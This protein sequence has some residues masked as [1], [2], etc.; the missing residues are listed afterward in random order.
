MPDEVTSDARRPALPRD[1][2]QAVARELLADMHPPLGPDTPTVVAGSASVDSSLP[3]IGPYEV[4]APLGR[5]GMGSVYRARDPRLDRVVALKVFDMG[6]VPPSEA[7]E[8][9]ERFRREANALAKLGNHRH[10]VQV[11]EL[12]HDG[13][14]WWFS[15]DLVE[16]MT[17]RRW[18]GAETRTPREV[19]SM[20]Q[21]VA[22]GLAHAHA[23]G[24]IHRDVK[25]EN[26]FVGPDG[27]PQLGDFGLVRDLDAS[28]GITE[29]G[30]VMGTVAY[31]APE[32]ALGA[33]DRIGAWTDVHAVG[34][35]LYEGLTGSHPF[36]GREKTEILAQVLASEPVPLRRRNPRAAPDLEAIVMRCLEKE[37]ERRYRDAGALAEDLRRWLDG[38]PVTATRLTP[39][40]WLRKKLHRHR[41]SLMVACVIAVLGGA[42]TWGV[43]VGPEA[44]ARWRARD[45]LASAM[46]EREALR[47]EDRDLVADLERFWHDH[48]GDADG[49]DALVAEASM[50]F[51]DARAAR[52]RAFDSTAVG[53]PRV[54]RAIEELLHTAPYE[55][56][57]AVTS[58]PPEAVGLLVAQAAE[59]RD[60]ALAAKGLTPRPMD[61]IR[62]YVGVWRGGHDPAAR[63]RALE[64]LGRLAADL[65]DFP[66][67]RKLLEPIRDSL[68]PEARRILAVSC[69]EAGDLGA[70]AEASDPDLLDL[71]KSCGGVQD[72]AFD[73]HDL[74]WAG[75]FPA[76]RSRT[77]T[78]LI[79]RGDSSLSRLRV[80][81]E[82]IQVMRTGRIPIP[83]PSR[84]VYYA[85]PWPQPDGAP[86]LLLGVPTAQ[87]GTAFFVIRGDNLDV[88]PGP[89]VPGSLHQISTGDIDGDGVTEA[90]ATVRAGWWGIHCLGRGIDGGAVLLGSRRTESVPSLVL[91]D[92]DGDHR[93][94]GILLLGEYQDFRLSLVR[95]ANPRSLESTVLA[96]LEGDG[97][98]LWVNGLVD[99]CPSGEGASVILRREPDPGVGERLH[100]SSL[101]TGCYQ[102]P[103]SR[104]GD[105]WTM[106]PAR[107]L[108]RFPQHYV[109]GVSV[110][111]GRNRCYACM[112]ESGTVTHPTVL[113]PGGD[114]GACVRLP[115][116]SDGGE[117]GM[118]IVEPLRLDALG[119]GQAVWMAVDVSKGLFRVAWGGTPGPRAIDADSQPDPVWV[120]PEFLRSRAAWEDAVD[121]YRDDRLPW[122]DPVRRKLALADTLLAWAD[123]APDRAR[124]AEALELYREAASKAPE[125]GRASSLVAKEQGFHLEEDALRL[126]ALKWKTVR[127]DPSGVGDSLVAGRPTSARPEQAGWSLTTA[128][129]APGWI[130]V[131]IRIHSDVVR[132]QA[133]LQGTTLGSMNRLEVLIC[134]QSCPRESGWP[135]AQQVLERWGFGVSVAGSNCFAKTEAHLRGV[136]ATWDGQT[137]GGLLWP[138]E[139]NFDLMASAREGRFCELARWGK[140]IPGWERHGDA[141]C[142]LP[143]G[144]CWFLV[145]GPLW[146]AEE[147]IPSALG[148]PCHAGLSEIAISVPAEG[149]LE[150]RPVPDDPD[151]L[152][153]RGNARA[154]LEDWAGARSFYR[155]AL[156]SSSV[157]GRLRAQIQFWAAMAEFRQGMGSWISAAVDAFRGDGEASMLCWTRDVPASPEWKTFSERLARSVL[158]AGL[159]AH[160]GDALSAIQDRDGP[161]L[162]PVLAGAQGLR[163]GHGWEVIRVVRPAGGEGPE[164]GEWILQVDSADVPS[165]DRPVDLLREVGDRAEVDLR[166]RTPA[167][168]ER[169]IHVPRQALALVAVR[170]GFWIGR[171]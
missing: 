27:E 67:A 124:L 23:H 171:P 146:T 88:L 60:R 52:A 38:E 127:L 76:G 87:G 149:S 91:L 54:R 109:R 169:T 164:V 19:A 63:E 94:E 138:L 45:L 161:S 29:E 100:V 58:E 84:R 85:V 122:T 65:D 163:T 134:P 95:F 13:G 168:I 117:G 105:R 9:T 21:R 32:Q 140:S 24:V 119:S 137:L 37:P 133:H 72:L 143:D 79:L 31:M 170:A 103:V 61:A 93:A 55:A 99:S 114:R 155:R 18:L 47:S 167:G 160:G 81:T 10:L 83:A 28:Q 135:S 69:L 131:P 11:H 121:V 92:A 86:A 70:A 104:Q 1:L 25:P 77:E 159:L 157:S 78:L 102:V 165:D 57:A 145:G 108:D 17:L 14:R 147:P 125:I 98:P 66:L 5:G 152:A 73:V 51:P 33:T 80:S 123:R 141:D 56:I 2:A 112:T 120:I 150:L 128:P 22:L 126:Q 89:V 130:G 144:D 20:V 136:C 116:A 148:T 142:P 166:V 43:T 139:G 8:R 106:G 64:G 50:R 68:S 111:I 153:Y 90:V 151:L 35:I 39:I 40:Y 115:L 110:A 96:T 42:L 4:L 44:R 46:R 34:V 12:G 82:G 113:L 71:V 41:R 7:A 6:Q 74:C 107:L 75:V 48:R 118:S 30:Q 15:M 156:D 158:G 59:E 129:G 162:I 26:V 132:L 53:D 36:E 3:R 154:L 101:D 16:G 62:S 49:W 97:V